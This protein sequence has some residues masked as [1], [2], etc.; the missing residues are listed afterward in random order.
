M[1]S[2]R[3]S[4]EQGN[5]SAQYNLGYMYQYGRGVTKSNTEAI[6]RYQ[7]AAAQGD[8]D[9]KNELKKLGY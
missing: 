1:K 5:A 3:K 4:V 6:K 8:I 7:K 9:A 2:F